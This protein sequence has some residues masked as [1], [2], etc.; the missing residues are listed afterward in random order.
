MD[1]DL[2]CLL[3]RVAEEVEAEIKQ[4]EKELAEARRVGAGAEE[5]SAIRDIL[6]EDKWFRI[7][8]AVFTHLKKLFAEDGKAAEVIEA[9]ERRLFGLRLEVI[10]A[11]L[12]KIEAAVDQEGKIAAVR[13]KAAI[14]V[15][16]EAVF[17]GVAPGYRL[18]E[19]AGASK[20]VGVDESAGGGEAAKKIATDAE[21]ALD[22]RRDAAEGVESAGGGRRRGE[23]EGR[24]ERLLEEVRREFSGLP[25]YVGVEDGYVKRTAPMDQRQFRKYLETCKR[26]GFRFDRRGERWVKPLEE[27]K[28]K[29]G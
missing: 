18:E 6:Y 5:L 21:A 8:T 20:I 2:R 3:W 17:E 28:I 19:A 13:C 29:E 12:L 9:A 23:E 4:V 22:E 11:P 10:E 26:L 24:A 14:D 7:A 16:V 25:V 15:G 27:L 1:F